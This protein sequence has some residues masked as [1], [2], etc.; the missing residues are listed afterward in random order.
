MGSLKEWA[1]YVALVARTSVEMA[2]DRSVSE[3][4]TSVVE[5]GSELAMVFDELGRA[6]SKFPTWPDDPLHAV[7]VVNEEAGELTRA[8]LQWAYEGGDVE[9]VQKEAVQTAAMAIRFLLNLGGYAVRKSGQLHDG[10]A[11]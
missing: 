2:M 7:A 10:G 8:V 1:R 5:D 9:N 6:K 4:N 3:W 11:E